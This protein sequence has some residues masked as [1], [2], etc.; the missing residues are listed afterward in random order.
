[1]DDGD[2]KEGLTIMSEMDEVEYEDLEINIEWDYKD[3]EDSD[4]S[5]MAQ[6]HSNALKLVVNALKTTSMT[7]TKEIRELE[8]RM[9]AGQGPNDIKA[10]AALQALVCKHSSLAKA[11]TAAMEVGDLAAEDIEVLHNNMNRFYQEL[12]DYTTMAEVSN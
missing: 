10:R 2:F 1:M 3:L 8:Q 7:T 9:R 5:P 4:W 12:Q 11:I 6:A